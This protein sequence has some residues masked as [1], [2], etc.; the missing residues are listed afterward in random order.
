MSGLIGSSK[1]SS[2]DTLLSFT[3]SLKSSTLCLKSSSDNCSSLVTAI[4]CLSS[5]GGSSNPAICFF[6][7]FFGLI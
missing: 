7:I 1:A 3:F 6:N 2:S 4:K 5:L